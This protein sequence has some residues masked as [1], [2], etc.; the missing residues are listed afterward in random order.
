MTYLTLSLCIFV[1]VLVRINVISTN[2]LIGG[3]TA[4]LYALQLG[5][6]VFNSP[7]RPEYDTE[8]PLDEYP[9]KA[10]KKILGKCKARNYMKVKNYIG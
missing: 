9:Q 4:S 8:L 1:I 6:A 10:L 7:P 3:C 5:I 2:Y